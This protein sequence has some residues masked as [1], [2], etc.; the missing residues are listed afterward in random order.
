MATSIDSKVWLV[1]GASQGLGLAISLGALAAGH[2]V[3]ACARNPDKA[4]REYPALVQQGGRWI[5]LDVTS[6]DTE[7]TVRESV[8]KEGRIDVVVNNAGFVVVGGVEDLE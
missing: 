8:E 4:A 7:Q 5:K 3:I 2:K 1:T 6:K